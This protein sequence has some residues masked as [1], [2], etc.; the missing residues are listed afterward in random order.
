MSRGRCR[1]RSGKGRGRSLPTDGRIDS[2]AGAIG[3]KR[4][5]R[6]E[7]A[8]SPWK[9]EALPLSYPRTCES[10]SK[11]GSPTVTV[12]TNHVAGGDLIE[13]RLPVAVTEA[14]GNVEILVP[15]M[16]KLED[17]RVILAAVDARPLPEELD[18][19]GGPLLDDRPFAPHGIGDV[20]LT[21]CCVVLLFVSSSTGAAVVVTLSSFL[22]SPGKVRDRQQ[23]PAAPTAPGHIARRTRHEHMFP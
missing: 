6:I 21:V 20:A 19:I 22:P 16:V 13:H 23:L 3:R 15:E 18:E 14:S 5:T 9:G 1:R 4:G 17:K 11:R 8:S 12:C 7:L 2:R 10:P